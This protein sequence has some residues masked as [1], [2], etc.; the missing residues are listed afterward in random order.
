MM[1]RRQKGSQRHR[2]CKASVAV[3]STVV[4][5]KTLKTTAFLLLLAMSSVT[6]AGSCSE[7]WI[8]VKPV[9]HDDGGVSFVA[10][11]L[12]DFPVTVTVRVRTRNL[13]VKGANPVTLTVPP[14]ESKTV[15]R[16]S[17]R[18]AGRSTWY[19]YN[20]DWAVGR[21]DAVHDDSV[22]YRFPYAE[23]RRYGILQGYGS[24]FSHTGLEYY[25]VD[26]NMPVGTPVHAA[27]D[28]V[29]ARVVEHN[30]RG[31]WEDGCG[32]F[33]NFVVVLHDDGTTGEYYHLRKDGALVEEGD[34]V[35]AGQLIGLSGNT[36]HTTMPHLHFG[37]YRAATWG[38]TESLPVRFVTSN[39]LVSRPRRGRGYIAV[40]LTHA[41]P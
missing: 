22:V 15:I 27:R 4:T 34:R 33:A 24:R 20:F 13:A 21:H 5:K 1:P 9:D 8:C 39:G 3:E 18:S 12:R 41:L 40:S 16:T 17:R 7:G 32:A 26:F 6:A 30:N 25:T 36:G 35:V 11:N 37:V 10:E 28:G 23:G 14:H 29:V 31:C 19:H 38:A 2:N